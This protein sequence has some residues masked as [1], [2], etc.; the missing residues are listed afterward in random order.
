MDPEAPI[1]LVLRD[2]LGISGTKFGCGAALCGAC[3]VHL[4]SEATCSCS[5]PRAFCR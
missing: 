1:L 5:T 3:T 2:T 4:D